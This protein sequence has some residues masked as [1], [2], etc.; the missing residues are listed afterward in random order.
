MNNNQTT[1]ELIVSTA[2]KLFY[3]QGYDNTTVDEIIEQSH[4][5]KGAFYHYFKGKDSLLS[6]LSYLFDKKYESVIKEIDEIYLVIIHV[7]PI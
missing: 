4:T 7:N 1:K 2:W 6:S 3:K 5:S